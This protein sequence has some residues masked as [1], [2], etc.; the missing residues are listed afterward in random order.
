MICVKEMFKFL[1][2]NEFEEEEEADYFQF[3]KHKKSGRRTYVY[4]K[5]VELNHKYTKY[6]LDSAGLVS[7]FQKRFPLN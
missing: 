5:H 6:C 2:S 4:T 7:K 1:K 3:F